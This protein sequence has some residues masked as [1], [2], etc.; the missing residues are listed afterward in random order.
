MIAQIIFI[1]LL[2]A[3]TYL[4]AKNVGKVRRNILLGRDTNRSD[5]PARR[6]K[7]MAKVALGQTKMTKRPVAAILHFFIYVGFVIINLEV[8]EIMIDGIFGS[9]R[10]FANPLGGLYSFLIGGFE[11]LAILVLVACV[12]FLARRNIL[13]LKRFSGVEM[14]EWP[15]SDA[16]YILLVEICLMT[17][18]LTMNAADYKLQLLQFGHY[19]KAGSF[20]VSSFIAPLLSNNA[21]TLV[22]T[23]RVCWWI[24]IVGILA[25][26]NYLP[27]SKHFHILLAFPNTYYSKLEPQGEFTNMAS[28]TNEVKAMLDPSFI[29]ETTGEIARFGAKDVTDL[30]WKNLMDAYTCTECGR[31][32]SVCPANITGKLLSPRKI[33]MDTRDRITEVGNNIDKHGK[34]HNDGKALLDNYITREELWACTTCNACVEACPVNINP[35]E[36]ITEMR[37][38]IVMEESQAPV[39]LNNMFGNVEN[40]GAPWK[41]SNADRLNWVDNKS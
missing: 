2:A 20:P 8:L 22:I 17:A 7:V 32:T 9:H 18:F 1:I 12:V 41:Y 4:F 16:N 25:F 5:Q 33:M 37:R 23:E 39:S 19:I 10:I 31:C 40:N 3:A 28:V 27:Y 35:L 26:L 21:D 38:Y 15:K 6:W 13:K 11:V 30:T 34:D 14:T 24:H 29:P 36:I